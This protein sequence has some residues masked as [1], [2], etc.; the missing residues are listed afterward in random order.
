MDPGIRRIDKI[1]TRFEEFFFPIYSQRM[2]EMGGG[3]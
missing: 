3:G 2:R 1:H